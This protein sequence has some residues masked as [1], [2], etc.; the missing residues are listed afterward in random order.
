MPDPRLALV[1][2]PERADMAAEVRAALEE[3]GRAYE[4][5]QPED[6]A[7]LPDAV[8]EAVA[9]G[10]EVVVAVGGDGTQRTAADRLRGTDVALA[11]VPG[12]TVN[13]LGRLHGVHDVEESVAAIL[14]GHRRTIDLGLVGVGMDVDA[15]AEVDR[16][17]PFMLNASSG[18]DAA[19]MTRL[20]DDVKALGRAGILLEGLRQLREDRPRHVTVVVDGDVAYAGRAMSVIVCNVRERGGEGFVFAP[21]ADPADGRI[22]AVVQRCDTLPTMIRTGVALLQHREPR[23][24]DYV[25]F[26]GER[27]EVRWTVDVDTQIDGDPTGEALV[28]AHAVE[29][30]ALTVL[31]GRPG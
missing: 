9:G 10:A 6:P 23:P 26:Q 25:A 30:G 2:N 24:E 13:M 21:Q 7:D 12:G 22:D 28:I 5:H 11:V 17:E 4:L 19:V 16:P 20:D 31:D 27:V 14:R 1:V 8:D 15:L 29:P 3:A 18:Y